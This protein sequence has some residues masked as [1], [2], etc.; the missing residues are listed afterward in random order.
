M[1]PSGTPVKEAVLQNLETAL[2]AIA[3]GAAYYTTVARVQR[4]NTVPIDLPEYPAIVLVPLGTDYDPPGAATTLA[5]AGH[6]R[7]QAT[8]IIRSRTDA[9]ADLENFIRD[10]HKALLVDP[11]R[12]GLAI[13]T[14]LVSD[15]VYYP[16]DIEEP[17]AL[18]DLVIEVH[19]RTTRTDLNQ[20]T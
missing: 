17:V 5:I 12:G 13:D 18:A 15:S 8:L 6:Y 2:A 4:I 10:V 20:A 16:T 3:A 11:T 7:V 14:R 1:P 19:Y 9:V